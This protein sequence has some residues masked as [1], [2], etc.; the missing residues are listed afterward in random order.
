MASRFCGR[1]PQNFKYAV[2][3]EI[4]KYQRVGLQGIEITSI[5]VGKN[6]NLLIE[7]D[8]FV[9]P[10]YNTLIR[11]ALRRAAITLDVSSIFCG[12]RN[13]LTYIVFS[14]SN[15]YLNTNSKNELRT[16]IYFFSVL[17]IHGIIKHIR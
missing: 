4:R 17:I 13:F 14:S 10:R 15:V 16:T 2:T 3:A 6:E 12:R 11:N 9:N 7:F 5:T 8:I 1:F